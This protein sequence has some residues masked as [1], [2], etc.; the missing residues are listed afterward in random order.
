M[1]AVAAVR[2]PVAGGSSGVKVA[3]IVFVCLTVVSLGLTIWLYTY[4]SDL[5]AEVQ[6][7]GQRARTADQNLREF[8]NQLAALAREMV[9]E[10]TSEPPR[11]RQSL[12]A[13][14]EPVRAD[15]RLRQVIA[16]D[17]AMSTILRNL[18]TLFAGQ[19][20][21]LAAVTAERDGL[22]KQV[23][24]MTA[25][26]RE[27]DAQF[28][29]ATERFEAR[30]REL[31][32][33]VASNRQK[34]DADVEQLRKQ[35][36]SAAEKAGQQLAAEREQAENLRKKAA[37]MQQRL[38]QLVAQL[39]SA[40]PQ[41]DRL[42]VLQISDGSVVRAVAGQDIA[43]ISIGRSDNVR[44]GMTFS[45]YSRI[46]GIPA[47]GRGKAALR[48]SHVFDT[49]SECA[50]VDSTVGDPI[51]EGD[52][53]ANP[54]YDKHRKY[55]FL[56]TGDF[57][58]DFDGRVDDPGGEKLRQLIRA[59]GGEVAEAVD[60][61]TDFVV[62]GSRPA[63]QTAVAAAEVQEGQTAALPSAERLEADRQAFD[64]IVQD[65]RGLSVPILTRTQFLHFMGFG[66]PRSVPDDDR[67]A[68]VASLG[69]ATA[70]RQANAR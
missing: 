35:L 12:T 3:M 47:D 11:I 10:E 41:A 40:R 33:A 32:Q 67:P 51:L 46:R 37:D 56:V 49:T 34:W 68:A 15:E 43:Y 22:Q 25:A 21:Q 54:V 57:D 39:A 16:P 55:R 63:Q 48:V 29:Q 2:P 52:I 24:G 62:A 7:A 20:E 6:A 45:V 19:S 31:E 42:S 28:A 64:R 4:Q 59:M 61:E 23:A 36:T 14:L 50:I 38:D 58:L 66:V 9:G 18:Y 30:V 60:T 44:P 53:I 13:A 8:Q 65:A 5:S 69:G 70:D 26:A 27:N 17:A 1:S